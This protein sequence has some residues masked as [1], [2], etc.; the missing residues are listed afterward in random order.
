[1]TLL[2]VQAF[3]LVMVSTA[4]CT[5]ASAFCLSAASFASSTVLPYGQGVSAWPG[6]DTKT[7]PCMSL[8]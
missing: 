2:P 6:T 5:K 1:M 4:C 8:H 7:P 3:E